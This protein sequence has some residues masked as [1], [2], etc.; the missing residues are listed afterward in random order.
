MPRRKAAAGGQGRP[1][2]MTGTFWLREPPTPADAWN[3]LATLRSGGPAY[4]PAWFRAAGMPT[5]R[6]LGRRSE[7]LAVEGLSHGEE[8]ELL[9]RAGAVPRTLLHSA[10]ANGIHT[11]HLSGPSLD[12]LPDALAFIHLIR[13]LS[14]VLRPVAGVF[15]E[16]DDGVPD[17]A[18]G[19]PGRGSASSGGH[20]RAKAAGFP[21]WLTVLGGGKVL[22]VGATRLLMAPVYLIDT[23][24]DGGLLIAATPLPRDVC[25]NAGRRS[26][27]QA[28][29]LQGQGWWPGAPFLGTE[30]LLTLT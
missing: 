9:R 10:V 26:T 21:G 1:S 23:L 6:I 18:G 11:I 15:A 28:V 20:L 4:T 3:L 19:T 22:E 7:P 25:A 12:S 24:E 27:A 2:T 17:G 5:A 13:A 16:Q 29:H 30:E 14:D 8:I